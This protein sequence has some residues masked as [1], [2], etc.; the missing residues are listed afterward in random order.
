MRTKTWNAERFGLA[1]SS[2][3]IG[4]YLKDGGEHIILYF[5]VYSFGLIG[6]EVWSWINNDLGLCIK[7]EANVQLAPEVMSGFNSITHKYCSRF[8]GVK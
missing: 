5:I 2:I 7:N 6:L 3:F 4:V 1:S 8:T